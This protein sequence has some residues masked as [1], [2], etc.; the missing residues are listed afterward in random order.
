MRDTGPGIPDSAKAHIFEPFFT[1]KGEGEG[2]GL[3]LS[4]SYGIVTAHGGTIEV[5]STSSACTTFRVALPAAGESPLVDDAVEAGFSPRSPLAGIR[6][7]FIDDEPS[8]RSGVQ[9]FGVLRGFT[10]LTAANG[11][12]GLEV[13]RSESV[14]AVVVDLHMPGMDG[15]AAALAIR[16]MPA[17]R[18]RV[19]IIAL[20][21]D[22]FQESREHARTAG[23]D[24]FLTKPAHLPELREALERYVGGHA[25]AAPP[26]RDAAS[27]E[28]GA[29]DL[30]TMEHVR[31]SLSAQTFGAL[32][33]G[34]FE[35]H[36]SASTELHRALADGA[37]A[38][39]RSRAHA[40]K[41][42]ALSLGLRSVADLAE[43][44]Q[45][46]QADTPATELQRRLDALDQAINL[47]HDLCVQ[48]GLLATP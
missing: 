26:T 2:T 18:G 42:A 21:A 4:V 6:L 36:A 33:A 29:F 12:E 19:P 14:D 39:L 30:A 38:E 27:D 35:G 46:T 7:L 15:F 10:V 34:F 16:A 41:G 20:T 44:L 5:P 17:P 43:Q 28:D 22:A 48:Q 11:V 47:V 9:A 1:T 32:L 24:G 40:L 37:H 8:L 31:Q 25:A 13:A 23:M 45:H 3:G